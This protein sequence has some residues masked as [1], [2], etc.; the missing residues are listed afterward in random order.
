MKN[1]FKAALSLVL[2]VSSFFATTSASAEGAKRVLIVMSSESAMGLSGKLT[3]TWFEEVATPYYTLREAGYEVVMASL[4]GGDAPIDLLS[5]QA[6]FTTANTDKFLNDA[7]AMQALKNTNKL[8]DL[9]VNDF[10]ALFVPGGY[11]LLWDLASDSF[12]IKMIEDFYADNKPVAMVCHA[13]AILRDAKKRN[14]EPLVKGL[15][16]TGF[17]NAEDD[18]LDLS[19]H[20]L[21]SLE[22]MLK[23]NGANYKGTKKN[24]QAHIEI[25]GPLM[26]GQNPAS[27]PVL[28]KALAKR[29]NK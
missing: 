5:M 16:V 9:N 22:D 15:T 12:T 23:A 2:V 3:G 21:F 10:D 25:D 28:A 6:P 14:G 26:T 13:P 11:G 19:R 8:S 18:E 27:A 20:L 1:I 4:K 7:V 17:M 29:L 24:W